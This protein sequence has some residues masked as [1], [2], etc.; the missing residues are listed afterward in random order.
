MDFFFDTASPYRGVFA[1]MADLNPISTT[2]EPEIGLP[3]MVDKK[4]R[5]YF[6]VLQEKR[7]R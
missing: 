5:T 6:Q 1:D 4:V 7:R 3:T 2:E